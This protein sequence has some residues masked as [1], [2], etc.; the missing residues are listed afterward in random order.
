MPN[1]RLTE[2]IVREKLRTLGYLDD[3]AIT[4]EEQRSKSAPIASLL[5]TASKSG[6]EKVGSPEFIIWSADAPDF[7]M[8][9]E[10]KADLA[11]H[12]STGL[13]DPVHFAVDGALHYGRALAKTFN[14]ICVA[15]SGETEKEALWDLFLIPKGSAVHEPI[16]NKH[17][18]AL[19][20][21]APYAELVEAA[22]FDEAVAKARVDDLMAF[23]RELHDFMREHAKLTESEK[24]LLVSGT[25]IA[26]Q[27]VA[28]SKTYG[29]YDPSEL[30]EEW[31][32]VIATE[33]KK[34][35][36]PHSKSA[37]MTAPYQSLAAHPEL[38]KSTKKWPRGP[39]YELIKNLHEKVWPF[40]TIYHDFD[41]VGQ[42]YGEFLKY[43]GGDKKSLGI[44]LTPRHVTELFA[45]LANVGVNSKVLDPAAGTGGFLI[46]SM[47]QMMRKATTDEQ[48]ES[49]K[50]DQLIGVEQQP[51]MFAL[52][53]SNMLL[54]GDGK[55]NLYQGNCFDPAIL[56]KLKG[57][58][59]NVGMVNPPYS[60]RDENLRELAFVELMLD[61]LVEGGTGIA[62]VPLKCASLDDPIRERLLRN[63]TLEAVMSMPDELF[64]PVATVTCI[65][66]FTAHK[67]H[68]DTDRKTWLGYWKDDG[69]LKTKHLGRTDLRGKWE[70]IRDEW[71]RQYRDRDTSA[72]T[73]ML[74][75]LD[76]SMEWCA[77]AYMETDYAAIS[78]ADFEKQLRYL[79]AFR[80]LNERDQ[81]SSVNDAKPLPELTSAETWA[82]WTITDLF[83]VSRGKELNRR[84]LEPGVTAYI[85][86]SD[87][88]NGVT[89]W[90]SRDPDHESGAVTLAY[91]GS[92]GAAFYQ[93]YPFC[94]NEKIFVLTPKVPHSAAALIFVAT[95]IRAEKYRF[96]YGRK[97]TA[98]R[99]DST[100]IR[101]PSK[102]EQPDWDL[103]DEYISSMRFSD[104]ALAPASV[105]ELTEDEAALLE[106]AAAESAD[107]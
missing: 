90:V 2:S 24:P 78:A 10:C 14:V 68:A 53:A 66:V 65:M 47:S 33:I 77:E 30:R 96:S 4:F 86:A 83:D 51:N 35:E 103:M 58:K 3:D 84:D 85:G 64:S 70:T 27:N 76:G 102:D 16:S 92:V 19:T 41:V 25:L 100:P 34:A 23:S 94:I 75:K 5:R 21:V 56:T 95:M 13:D 99:L 69:F 91:D 104:I 73:G 81:L 50:R 26:L 57:H 8:V 71:V 106:I 17:G 67:P 40:V 97:W 42:F 98:Q 54:R 44:V 12:K 22:S 20:Q 74:V 43:T 59:A 48:R 18:I 46:S 38:A 72:R 39:L 37:D 32:R 60:Q 45:L 80:L 87:R 6:T 88:D 36:I 107:F 105:R 62:I 61:A 93:P 11:H 1:E 29:D 9:V 89:A 31:L 63:H 82:D 28:F 52:A 79:A 15:V 55:A 7:V 101:L 49:I